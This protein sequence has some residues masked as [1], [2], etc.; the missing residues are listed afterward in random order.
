[1][2][3]RGAAF[4]VLLASIDL[5][6]AIVPAIAVAVL[7]IWIWRAKFLPI[8]VAVL[9]MIALLHLWNQEVY[10]VERVNLNI[11]ETDTQST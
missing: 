3:R 2:D 4:G 7:A 6:G 8:L 5:G 1:M 9:V 10:V 11:W